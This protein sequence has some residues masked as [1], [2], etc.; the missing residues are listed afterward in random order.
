M[1]IEGTPRLKKTFLNLKLFSI[2]NIPDIL[3]QHG[4]SYSTM[5]EYS[6]FIITTYINDLIKTYSK[7]KRIRGIIYSNPY[8]D[9]NIIPN[10]YELLSKNE[11]IH[12]IVL[13]DDYNVPKLQNLYQYFDEI[14]FFPSV[15][16]IRLIEA[17]KFSNLS[18]IEWKK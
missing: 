3:M 13:F 12:Q 10:I 16:K 17:Q 7:S 14:I 9:E 5:D 1:T 8:I 11:N 2:I 18:N 4:Y 15:K 6:S